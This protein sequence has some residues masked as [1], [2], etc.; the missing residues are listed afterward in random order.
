MNA[1]VSVWP[2]KTRELHNHHFDSTVWND[3]A[4]R[5]DDIV[6]GT[7]AKSG[8]TWTQQIVAQLLFQG[9][10]DLDVAD[11]SPWIDLRVPPKAMKL[12]AVEQQ[13]HRRFLKTHLPVDALVFSPKARYIYVGRDGRDVVWSMY[14]H[15]ANANAAWYAALN[16]T[17]GRVGPPIEPPPASI[18]QYFHDWL[19]RDGHPF[20]PFWENVRS[21][22]EVRDLP[23]VLLVHFAEMKADMPGQIRRIAD[24]L[25]IAIDEA[26]WPAIIEHCSFEYMQ[27]HAERSAPLNGTFWQGGARTFIN[28][29]TNG[30]WRD[31]LTPA[32]SAVYEAI[33]RDRLGPACARWL[34]TGATPR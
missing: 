24:F 21:W 13:R 25:G 11:M 26:R 8:T 17:P 28:K 15:H 7:Y 27:A 18:R 34:A 2:Q 22:W 29:G 4:F 14:N 32:E 9:A 10:E 16:E 23:N 33:A 1:P 5:D 20:W 3:F 6:I 31:V 19:E 12:A 30:R